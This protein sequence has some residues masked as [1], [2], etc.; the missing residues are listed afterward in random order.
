M[1]IFVGVIIFLLAA[2][3]FYM[4]FLNLMGDFDCEW[5][6]EFEGLGQLVIMFVCFFVACM[7]VVACY[8]WLAYS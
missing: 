2:F 6:D 1:V 5:F 8:C 3:L 7:D 4:G